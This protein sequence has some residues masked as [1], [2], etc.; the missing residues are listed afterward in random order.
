M[1]T[2]DFQ[3]AYIAKRQ[4]QAVHVYHGLYFRFFFIIM[5]SDRKACFPN[6]GAA[7]THSL[8][9]DGIDV[10]TKESTTDFVS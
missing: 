7:R 10:Y 1:S 5:M 4:Y 6:L 8:K 3:K 9:Y 2:K